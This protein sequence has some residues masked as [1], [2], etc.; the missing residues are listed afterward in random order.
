[1]AYPYNPKIAPAIGNGLGGF[2]QKAAAVA[3]SSGAV[4]TA[5]NSVIMPKL[6]SPLSGNNQ[7]APYIAGLSGYGLQAVIQNKIFIFENY[8]SSYYFYWS[9]LD[10]DTGYYTGTRNVNFGSSGFS[11]NSDA[12]NAINAFKKFSFTLNDDDSAIYSISNY[13]ISQ[14]SYNGSSVSYSLVAVGNGYSVT[15]TKGTIATYTSV[16]ID[17]G[18]GQSNYPCIVDNQSGD[19]ITI[20]MVSS[21]GRVLLEKRD[22][23]IL[24]S[25]TA[26]VSIDIFST[27]TYKQ[28][29]SLNQTSNG[30]IIV[31]VGRQIGT[32]GSTTYTSS[33]AYIYV[34][35]KDF[36]LLMSANGSWGETPNPNWG[37]SK[38]W[39]SCVVAENKNYVGISIDICAISDKTVAH[40]YPN[41]RVLY[42]KG[43]YT[44]LFPTPSFYQSLTRPTWYEMRCGRLFMQYPTG[45]NDGDALDRLYAGSYSLTNIENI[46]ETQYW[47]VVNGSKPCINELTNPTLTV[48][49]TNTFSIK[50]ENKKVY[51]PNVYTAGVVGTAMPYPLLPIGYA[52]NGKIVCVADR[53]NDGYSHA[54]ATIATA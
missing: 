43:S 41:V 1:M 42:K 14:L 53:P 47:T 21:T 37:Y 20:G 3:S 18:D 36:N 7:I 6:V 54:V 10:I 26:A 33:Y 22:K 8:S 24:S 2:P 40:T 28:S 27:D 29:Y 49:E 25:I 46:K 44:N 34:Y 4:A 35:D 45:G 48:F 32:G 13:G 23:T 39:Q 17:Y 50:Y 16:Y 12:G 9:K 30:D 31:G 19:L 51:T 5:T 38:P 15:T 11:T 52:S